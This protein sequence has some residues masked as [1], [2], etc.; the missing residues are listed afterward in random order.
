MKNSE[1]ELTRKWVGMWK[2][3]GPALEKI[4]RL[5][6]RK[7]DYPVNWRIVDALLDS[8]AQISHPRPS[9]MV[10]MQRYFMKWRKK[11]GKKDKPSS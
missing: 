5:E 3:A 10:V 6:L 11:Q 8:A 2:K 1:R 9:G 7:F 4:R